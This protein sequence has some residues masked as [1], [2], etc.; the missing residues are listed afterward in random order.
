MRADEPSSAG[1]G[2]DATNNALVVVVVEE[3]G[4]V[5]DVVV[6]KV[7]VVDGDAVSA[8][9][10][11]ATVLLATVLLATVLLATVVLA[12]VVSE[13]VSFG[14]KLSEG[15]AVSWVT[16]CESRTATLMPSSRLV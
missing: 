7:L 15:D 8:R 4:I 6:L 5:L 12:T 14:S 2:E 9:V 11:S 13:T 1:H 3:S 16:G 10:V